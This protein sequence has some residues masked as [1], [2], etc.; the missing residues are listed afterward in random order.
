MKTWVF[1]ILS[2]AACV[3]QQYG[4]RT[5]LITALTVRFV[6]QQYKQNVTTALLE[7]ATLLR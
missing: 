7:R 3:V 5:A 1:S 2:A 6:R 4:V